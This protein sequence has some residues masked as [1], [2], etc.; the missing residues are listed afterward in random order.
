MM[1]DETMRHT[2]A[3]YIDLESTCWNRTPPP[4]LTPEIIEIGVVE[5]DL[6]DLRITQEA[7]YFVRPR[8]WEISQKCTKLTGITSDDVRH[9]MTFPK[10]LATVIERFRPKATPCC[11]WGDDFSLLTKACNSEGLANPF[12]QPIDLCKSFQGILA[13]K[14]QPS[15]ASALELMGLQFEGFPHGALNDARNTAR[16]HIAVLH[17]MRTK[18]ETLPTSTNVADQTESLSPFAQKLAHALKQ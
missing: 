12:R 7:A 8:R 6:T 17:H 10:V 3:L 1:L 5:L 16:L 9:A 4:G 15:L 14:Q 13:A 2:R 11:A 18:R